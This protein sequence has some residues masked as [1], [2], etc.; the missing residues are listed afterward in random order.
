MPLHAHTCRKTHLHR[1]KHHLPTCGR[2]RDHHHGNKRH[3]VSHH[4]PA[5]T[6]S[7]LWTQPPLLSLPV[8]FIHVSS[9]FHSQLHPFHNIPSPFLFISPH[10]SSS[11]VFSLRVKGFPPPASVSPFVRVGLGEGGYHH[12]LMRMNDHSSFGLASPP[13]VKW[14]TWSWVSP[15]LFSSVGVSHSELPE[16]FHLRLLVYLEKHLR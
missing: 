15:C 9:V 3:A 5:S 13:S 16:A 11:V 2:Q 8:F 6:P 12:D 14:G 4:P 1:L 7:S 10:L